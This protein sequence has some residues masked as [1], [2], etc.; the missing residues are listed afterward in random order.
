MEP[1]VALE[2]I[3]YLLD[4]SLAPTPKVRAFLRARE[5]VEEVG[6]ERLAE[7]HSTN[8]LKELPGIGDATGTVIA[9]ALDGEVPSYLRSWRTPPSS[10]SAR[11]ARSAPP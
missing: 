6:P 8:S 3:V 10:P 5:I 11:A 1:A 4:R 7:L 9:E 2:R